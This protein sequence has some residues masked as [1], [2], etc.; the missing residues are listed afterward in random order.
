MRVNSAICNKNSNGKWEL[1]MIKCPVC[2]E[3]EFETEDNYEICEICGWENEK[4]QTDHPD[5]AECANDICLNEAKKRWANGETIFSGF[6]NPRSKK[7]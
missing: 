2:G 5:E 4:F 1:K 3:Y 6:P 7:E